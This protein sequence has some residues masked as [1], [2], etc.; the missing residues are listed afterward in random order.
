MQVQKFAAFSDGNAGGNPAGVVIAEELPDDAK[1]QSVATEVGFS[2]T[3]FAA[4]QAGGYRVRF[5][6]QN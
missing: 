5:F 3:V 4:A 1:M 6:R 2:E